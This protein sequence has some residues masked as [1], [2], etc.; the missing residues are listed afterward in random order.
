MAQQKKRRI[1]RH[2]KKH[3]L[4]RF[5][6][7]RGGKKTNRWETFVFVKEDSGGANPKFIVE[8][9]RGRRVESQARA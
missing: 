4:S 3:R 6:V 2:T 8:H 7:C 5:V 9:S 1:T